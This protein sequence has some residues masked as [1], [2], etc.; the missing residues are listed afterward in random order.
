MI[1]SQLNNLLININN[2]TINDVDILK[3]LLVYEL[4]LYF[5]HN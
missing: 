2:V 3:E 1:K 4:R 5:N